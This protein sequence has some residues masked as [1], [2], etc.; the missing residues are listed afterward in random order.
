MEFALILRELSRR[1]RALAVGVIVAGLASLFSIY[2]IGSG[3][4][5]KPRQLQYSSAT[6][7]VFIDTPSSVLGN[8]TQAI[9][10]LQARATVFANFMA[11][12]S[13][14]DL[15]GEKSGIPADQIYAAG[16]IDSNVPRI[17]EEPTAIQR[18]VELTGET[19]PYRLNFNDDPNLPT[20]GVYAQAPTTA[21]SVDLA[22]AAVS[23]LKL[24]VAGLQ[25][26]EHTPAKSRIVIRQLGPAKGAVVNG[27]IS[28]ALASMAFFG[29]FFLWCVL[30]LVFTRFRETWRQSANL[31]PAPLDLPIED[32]ERL[33]NGHATPIEVRVAAVPG[34][35]RLGRSETEAEQQPEQEQAG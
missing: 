1:P 23:A 32:R 19:K 34:Q 8:I 33:S 18:N 12:P 3:L 35:F 21:Q 15:I 14:L 13:V 22:E 30:M 26:S 2:T 9:E 16:P 25:N 20:I 17:I 7:T 6:T 10:P 4:S 31:H 24:Y 29:V 27:G 11:S 28:K 5:L